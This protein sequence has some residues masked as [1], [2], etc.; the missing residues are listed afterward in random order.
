MI[1]IELTAA[2]FEMIPQIDIKSLRLNSELIDALIDT[3]SD[4]NLKSIETKLNFHQRIKVFSDLFYARLA[5]SSFKVDRK[6]IHRH[7]N[8]III[9]I[10]DNLKNFVKYKQ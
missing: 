3:F 8:A 10:K 7:D 4:D 5:S 6:K 9:T 1:L 2:S